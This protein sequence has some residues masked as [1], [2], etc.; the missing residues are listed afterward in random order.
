MK[1]QNSTPFPE[2]GGGGGVY[3]ILYHKCRLKSIV[4]IHKNKLCFYAIFLLTFCVLSIIIIIESEKE[5]ISMITK[6]QYTAIDSWLKEKTFQNFKT[7]FIFGF[8]LKGWQRPIWK[9]WRIIRNTWITK[10]YY[11]IYKLNVDKLK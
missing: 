10:I 4:K 7:L 6:V 5:V 11:E 8:N 3:I 9:C 1:K 2:K